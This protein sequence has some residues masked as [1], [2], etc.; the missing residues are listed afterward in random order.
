MEVSSGTVFFA[1][2][3]V[4]N[5]QLFDKEPGKNENALDVCKFAAQSDNVFA[6]ITF[7]DK[8]FDP[9]LERGFMMNGIFPPAI[10]FPNVLK[11][12][13]TVACILS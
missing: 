11:L 7:F 2:P 3:V 13:V 4:Y 9:I 10:E 12:F 6:V 8:G 5:T 1:V